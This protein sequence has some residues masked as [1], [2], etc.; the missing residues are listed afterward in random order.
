MPPADDER[1]LEPLLDPDHALIIEAPASKDHVLSAIA[2][3]AA[4]R[5]DGADPAKLA[6]DL[7][8]REL[9]HPTSTPEGVAFPHAMLAEIDD[10]VLVT[11][12][13]RPGVSF[14][15]DSHPATDIVFA[16]FGNADKPFSHIRVLAR[17][18]RLARG[19]G[20]LQR[21]RGADAA[22]ALPQALVS[23]DRRHA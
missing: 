21:F 16:I 22:A 23:A 10:T 7:T 2:E 18:A 15:V 3:H 5:I 4:H 1:Q 19:D 20:A 9:R 11:A 12:L 14:G 17:L 8:D 13:L 6:S